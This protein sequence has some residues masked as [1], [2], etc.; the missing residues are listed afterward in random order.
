MK[1][2]ASKAKVF[3]AL[4]E[5]I[6]LSI[7]DLLNKKDCA[8]IC[9]VTGHIKRDQSVAFRHIKILEEAGLITT[10]KDGRY[11]WC[12]IKDKEK[13]KRILEA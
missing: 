12:C 10:R 5:P 1:S 11:L 13:M 9:E 2:I 3:K 4:S 6:R 8:C 7:L